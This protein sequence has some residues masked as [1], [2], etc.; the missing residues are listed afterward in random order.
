[1]EISLITAI[2]G[3][4]G[5]I[6]SP[7]ITLW[8]KDRIERRQSK[9]LKGNGDPKGLPDRREAISGRWDG[10]VYQDIGP[11]GS[12]IEF[13][14]EWQLKKDESKIDGVAYFE[15]NGKTINL[16]LSGGFIDDNY[17]QIDYK[18][19]DFR[20]L[21][22]GTFFFRISDNSENLTGRFLGYAAEVGNLI[23]GEA[24]AKKKGEKNSL[25]SN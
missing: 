6:S 1:M 22:Y 18:D 2:I 21:R 23:Y 11:D 12:P 24:K 3:V 14:I 4:V 5:T 20:V 19:E 16:K 10:R 25:K 9:Y 17:I 7:I 13:D 15:W 8:V